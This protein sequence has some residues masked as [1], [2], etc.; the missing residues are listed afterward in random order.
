MGPNHDVTTG[1]VLDSGGNVASDSHLRRYLQRP[2]YANDLAS[3]GFT[4]EHRADGGPYQDRCF[5]LPVSTL[6][7]TAAVT[8]L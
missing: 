7:R 8:A 3:F 4:E 1:L 5:R 6:R 2:N